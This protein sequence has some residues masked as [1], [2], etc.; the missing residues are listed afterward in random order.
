[1]KT[2]EQAV[3]RAD[4]RFFLKTSATAVAGLSL[5]FYLP[6]RSDASNTPRLNAWVEVLPNDTVVIRYARTEMGQGSRTSA[7]QLVAEEL[8]AD[9]SRVRV[10]Y[11]PAHE[12]LA[13]KRA[14]GD[15]ATVGSR[16]IRQSQDYLRKAG[17]TARHMLVAAAAQQWGV[18][19]SDCTT[20]KGRVMHA[21][22]KRSLSYGKLAEAAT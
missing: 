12:N 9:W 13:S 4:R 21:A 18:P 6:G 15:M 5:G 22:S 1:M 20:A 16:T 3:K 7:P 17:A 2:Q 14:Y 11:V 19:A 10:E 8:D